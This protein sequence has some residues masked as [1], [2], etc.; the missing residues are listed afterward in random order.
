MDDNYRFSDSSDSTRIIP[1]SDIAP[2]MSL[3]DW[4]IVMVICILP[5][6]NIIV[7][8]IW[9]FGNTDNPNRRNFARAFLIIA[10][11]W[12]VITAILIGQFTGMIISALNML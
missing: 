4:V 11:S 6:A 8:L 3:M 12:S 7:M 10:A 1:D 9:A 2:V 5:L